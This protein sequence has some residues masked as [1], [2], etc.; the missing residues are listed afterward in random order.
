MKSAV[1]V[2]TFSYPSTASSRIFERVVFPYGL[3]V[4]SVAV[5]LGIKLI[6]LHFGFPYPLSTS[7]LLAIALPFWYAGT[8][9]GILS[10]LL[11][12]IAF[13]FFVLPYQMDYRIV[14]PDGST[15]PVYVSGVSASHIQYFFYF[16]LL[17]LLMSWFS[18]SRRRA[19]QSLSQARRELQ[20]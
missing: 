11:S 15:K 10:V 7:F 1:D 13:A 8:G 12:F 14:L 5:A 18:S 6:L 3:A 2:G 20:T 19:E 4:V 17:A 9:P 16:A